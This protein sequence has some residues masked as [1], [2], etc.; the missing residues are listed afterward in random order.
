[1]LKKSPRRGATEAA[2]LAALRAELRGGSRLTVEAIATTAG[3]NK[4]LV[5]RYFGGLNGLLRAFGDSAEFMPDA[6][7]ILICSPNLLEEADARARFNALIQAYIQCLLVRPATVEILLRLPFLEVDV[8]R[9]LEAGRTRH[10]NEVKALFAGMSAKSLG[11]DPETVFSLLIGG[12]AQKLSAAH[13]SRSWRAK[14]MPIEHLAKG[15]GEA[16]AGMLIL[17]SQ[18]AKKSVLSPAAGRRR[19]GK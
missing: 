19:D 8:I 11:F 14:R 1:M 17:R 10:I 9:S 5:Y 4:A 16:V 12:I 15:I 6:A 18:D 3:I 2:L 13:R 7:E